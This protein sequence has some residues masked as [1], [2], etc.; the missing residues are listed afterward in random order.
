MS[1]SDLVATAL[2]RPALTGAAGPHTG[3]TAR[4]FDGNPFGIVDAPSMNAMFL[5]AAWWGGLWIRPA[6]VEAGLECLYEAGGSTNGFSLWRESDAAVA[7]TIRGNVATPIATSAG[8]AVGVWAHVAWRVRAGDVSVALNGGAW[9]VASAAGT[10]ANG[11][12]DGGIGGVQG[13]PSLPGTRNPAGVDV[14]HDGA[15][16]TGDLADLCVFAGDPTD[17]QF[18]T[19]VVGGE[20]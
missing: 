2:Y 4:A 19:L 6:E 20:R 1:Y 7:V 8:L 9:S 12:D 14:V 3:L 11:G 15:P 17:D 18:A 13:V 16:Y 5:P 10:A